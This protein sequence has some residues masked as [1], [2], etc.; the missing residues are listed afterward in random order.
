MKKFDQYRTEVCPEIEKI[1]QY[2]NR[3]KVCPEIEK[4]KCRSKEIRGG[5]YSIRHQIH[6][7]R[8]ICNPQKNHFASN[9]FEGQDKFACYK[10]LTDAT[11]LFPQT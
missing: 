2:G 5:A 4:N 6:T 1:S 9:I 8:L 3:T 7:F 10:V 11:N